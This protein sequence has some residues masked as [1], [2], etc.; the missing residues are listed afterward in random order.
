MGIYHIATKKKHAKIKI[1][2]VCCLMLAF[3]GCILF[4]S[5]R[6]STLE[7]R[8]DISVDVFMISDKI[9]IYTPLPD[10]ILFS[11]VNNSSK[12]FKY[13][14]NKF[15]EKNIDGVWYTVLPTTSY[16]FGEI[17]FKLEPFTRVEYAFFVEP[18]YKRLVPGQYRIATIMREIV[19]NWDL[20]VKDSSVVFAEFI[21]LN[22]DSNCDS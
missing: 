10:R 9:Y 19:G 11:L 7:R 5:M 13:G 20:T 22:P 14:H 2:V 6:E 15:I 8:Y 3:Q 1:L 18:Y 4:D 12:T 21:I 16:A 17:A